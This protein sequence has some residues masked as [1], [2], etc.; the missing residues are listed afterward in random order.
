MAR[1]MKVERKVKEGEILNK[2]FHNRMIRRNQNILN[3]TTGS[4]GCLSEG[5]I[6]EGQ[7]QSLGDLYSSGKRII[8]TV[9]ISQPPCKQGK[10][11]GYYPK[12]SK[13]EIIKSGIK[14]VL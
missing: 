11:G 6:V 9:S 14:E 4:P 13:S 1:L 7:T 10:H 3:A 5:T 8:D 2:W 12:K